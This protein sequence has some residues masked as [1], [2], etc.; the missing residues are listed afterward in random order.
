MDSRALPIPAYA[1]F[2][3]WVIK[4]RGI[5]VCHRRLLSDG[6]PAREMLELVRELKRVRT[7]FKKRPNQVAAPADERIREAYA[8]LGVPWSAW[9]EV[10]T[11][12]WGEVS[13]WSRRPRT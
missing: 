4:L 2:K 13:A 10:A 1:A 12:P 5:P 9:S 11:Q 8:A 7:D 6:W 3:S